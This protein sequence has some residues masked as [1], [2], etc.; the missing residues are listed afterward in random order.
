M[1]GSGIE[2]SRVI[3]LPRGDPPW[4]AVASDVRRPAMEVTVRLPDE[5]VTQ[6][7]DVADMPRQLLE[8]FAIEN[9]RLERLTRYQV[10][11]LL[12]LDYWRTEELLAEHKAT[13]PYELADFEVDR[14]SLTRLREKR[15]EE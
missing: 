4:L 6:L 12:G 13:A 10:S 3:E 2:G 15:G 5:I 7:A 14:A 8:A 11:Q 1:R 9:Y